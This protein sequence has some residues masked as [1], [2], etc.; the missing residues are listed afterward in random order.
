M[1]PVSCS[2][3]AACAGHAGREGSCGEK[4][5]CVEVDLGHAPVEADGLVCE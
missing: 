2:A 4:V 3:L 5:E 1:L